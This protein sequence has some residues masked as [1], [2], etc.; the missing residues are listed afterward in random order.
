MHWWVFLLF[1]FAYRQNKL[2]KWRHG[3]FD[4]PVLMFLGILWR[5]LVCIGLSEP[6]ITFSR[7]LSMFSKAGFAEICLCQSRVYVLHTKTN[8][9]AA[10]IPPLVIFVADKKKKM[11]ASGSRRA[12]NTFLRLPS[13][14][15]KL[16]S[17][18]NK[19][20]GQS[21]SLFEIAAYC[22]TICWRGKCASRK[23]FCLS[24]GLWSTWEKI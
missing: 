8:L 16:F 17:S 9:L 15:L 19:Q 21:V 2:Q 3:T 10:Q 12:A 18:E 23:V 7:D 11:S 6:D 14:R 24:R 5:L 20:F 1:K 22:A 13:R 4:T